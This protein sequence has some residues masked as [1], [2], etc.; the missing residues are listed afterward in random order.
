MSSDEFA[1]ALRPQRE[2]PAARWSLFEDPADERSA[3]GSQR[4]AALSG[5]YAGREPA[6]Y[7]GAVNELAGLR[8]VLDLG[9]GPGLA[10][11]AMRAAGV[12]D[13]VGVDRW[14]AFARDAQAAGERIVP[15]DLTLPMPF[16]DSGRFDGVFSHF[17]LDYVSPIGLRQVAREAH[18]LLEP[19]GR[20]L[21]M[22]ARTGLGAGDHARTARF[23]AD[24]LRAMFAEAGFAD[25]SA[26][27]V[28]EGRN[29]VVRARRE[30]GVDAPPRHEFDPADGVL[31]VEAGGEVQVS[32]GLED[33]LTSVC[34]RAVRTGRDSYELQCW[35]WHGSEPQ[36]VETEV[37]SGPPAQL[38]VRLRGG[39]APTHL[40]VWRPAL[41][42]VEPG[43]DAYAGDAA[44]DAP[45]RVLVHQ[46][47]QDLEPLVAAAQADRSA[48]VIARAP[49]E[50]LDELWVAGSV[51]GVAVDDP[52]PADL[53]WAERREAIVYLHGTELPRELTCP[54]VVVDPALRGGEPRAR[55]AALLASND[56]VYFA[57]TPARVPGLLAEV[58]DDDRN[59][60][61]AG[62][63]GS[64]APPT[65]EN[66]RYLTDR[67]VL[68]WL[69][70]TAPRR[71]A[72]V[73]RV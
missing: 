24:A 16:F 36:G 35:T 30:P 54:L 73:G 39:A 32:A 18:R 21:F 68:A 45:R 65:A 57:T 51:H 14:P 19:G 20:V 11:R 12:R 29:I 40:D 52:S 60:L 13:P 69:R 66:L 22:L 55:V 56:N 23:G 41:L 2:Y 53:E 25:Y 7:A 31:R 28:P 50:Q 26:E 1:I 62:A 34:M 46:P 37:V 9:A 72:E 70:Q 48:F 59:R 8:S 61:L 58:G 64:A 44:G 49:V 38:V 47:G 63:D 5:F 10:L 4:Y 3:H 33:G 27:P 17:A 43:A 42:E 6:W 15:H 71:P 67:T